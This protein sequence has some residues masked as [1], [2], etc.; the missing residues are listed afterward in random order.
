MTNSANISIVRDS[1]QRK[2]LAM[3]IKKLINMVSCLFY[4]FWGTANCKGFMVLLVILINL[5]TN[6]RSVV[7]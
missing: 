6:F 4:L 3:L 1:S 7:F 5:L 2:D